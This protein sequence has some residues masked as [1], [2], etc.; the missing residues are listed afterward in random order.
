MT[1][2]CTLLL[3]AMLLKTVTFSTPLST[4]RTGAACQPLSA[5][6][7]TLIS[8]LYSSSIPRSSRRTWQ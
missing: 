1:M 3:S 2:S 6:V 8:G 4:L 5:Q 7:L